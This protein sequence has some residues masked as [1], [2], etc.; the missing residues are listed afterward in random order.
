MICSKCGKD[1]PDGSRFC[2][3]CGGNVTEQEPKKKKQNTILVA[4]LVLII[5]GCGGY[6]ITSGY[7]N[8]P[9]EE[10]GRSTGVVEQDFTIRVTGDAG[11]KF[12]GSYMIVSNSG[13]SSS[14]SV[15]GVTPTTYNATGKIISTSFQKKG[16]RG[17]LR[18]EILRG[19]EVVKQSSTSAE[20]GVVSV[21]TN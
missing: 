5:V 9:M 13:S 14:Q 7:L 17:N 12:H 2:L 20:Y 19:S 4:V 6:L 1:I 10:L 15:E 3:E 21:A 8:E 16:E 11:L 18:V